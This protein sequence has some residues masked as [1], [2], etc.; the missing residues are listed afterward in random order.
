MLNCGKK[1]QTNTKKQ[2]TLVVHNLMSFKVGC[3][4]IPKK[5]EYITIPG[6]KK[7]FA[8]IIKIAAFK[9][10]IILDYPS[11]PKLIA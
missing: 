1:N 7:V 6:K 4:L 11:A 9:I 10:E 3:T 2:C 8:N 5:H